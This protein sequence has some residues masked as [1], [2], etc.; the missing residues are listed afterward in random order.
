MKA[1]LVETSVTIWSRE[2][3]SGFHWTTRVLTQEFACDSRLRRSSKWLKY[4]EEEPG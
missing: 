4:S 1:R 2:I 3:I